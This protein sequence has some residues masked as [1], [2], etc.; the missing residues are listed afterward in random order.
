MHR[1]VPYR[2]QVTPPSPSTHSGNVEH[3]I[4]EDFGRELMTP[5][6]YIE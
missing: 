4:L 6:G 5:E 1:L 2:Y 3:Y